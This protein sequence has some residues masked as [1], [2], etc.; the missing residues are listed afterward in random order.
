MWISSIFWYSCRPTSP[1]LNLS[2]QVY[3]VHYRKLPHNVWFP[4]G[5]LPIVPP[6][7]EW[8][9]LIAAENPF[10]TIQSTWK[11]L[12]NDSIK[13]P[14]EQFYLQPVTVSFF[15]VTV[16]TSGIIVMTKA[17]GKL[18]R[19]GQPDVLRTH[20]HV[21]GIHTSIN[22]DVSSCRAQGDVCPYRWIEMA[23]SRGRG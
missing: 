19:L 7:S 12:G 16:C 6:L 17:L 23:Y 18:L 3:F 5:V 14:V 4:V 15:Q 20:M 2:S 8:T 11:K 13:V 21:T 22:I 1:P 10:L 9:I